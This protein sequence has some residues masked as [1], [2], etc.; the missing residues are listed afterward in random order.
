MITYIVWKL[1]GFEDEDFNSHRIMVLKH[2]ADVNHQLSSKQQKSIK[3]PS[4]SSACLFP[5]L[6]G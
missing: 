5:P 6:T 4:R 1:N 2:K 3:L